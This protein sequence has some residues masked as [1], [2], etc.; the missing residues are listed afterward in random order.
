MVSVVMNTVSIIILFLF[1]RKI[2]PHFYPQKKNHLNM[3][4]THI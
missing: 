2:Y 1:A 3:Q 4:N